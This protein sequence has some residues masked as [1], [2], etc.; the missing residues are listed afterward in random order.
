[1]TTFTI[2]MSTFNNQLF[3]A[4]QLYFLNCVRALMRLFSSADTLMNLKIPRMPETLP[5][6]ITEVRLFSSVDTL[7]SPQGP[8]ATVTLPTLVTDVRL[9]SGVDMLMTLKVA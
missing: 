5:T 9:L 1:M 8:R 2:H 4:I 6:L 3:H 7:M